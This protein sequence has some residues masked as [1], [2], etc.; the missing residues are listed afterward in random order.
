MDKYAELR[1]I[2]AKASVEV[3]G[4]PMV[5]AGR[6]CKEMGLSFR[7]VT[8]DGKGLMITADCKSDRIGFIINNGIV[9]DV[10]NG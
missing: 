8:V 1:E 5:E 7:W 6:I 3:I 2:V 10:C 4:K 9:T